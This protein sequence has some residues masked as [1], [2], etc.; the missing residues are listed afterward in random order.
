V[1]FEPAPITRRLA[2]DYAALVRQP[3]AEVTQ[4]A[5]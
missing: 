1:R 5:A 3:V 4:P 2:D